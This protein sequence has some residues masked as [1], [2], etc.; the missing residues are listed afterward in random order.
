MEITFVDQPFKDD[1]YEAGLKALG[2]IG[3]SRVE[4]KDKRLVSFGREK[5]SAIH[6]ASGLGL[7]QANTYFDLVHGPESVE[8]S[9][10]LNLEMLDFASFFKAPFIRVFTGPLDENA[11]GT[12]RADEETWKL[13]VKGLKAICRA[14]AARNVFYP[15]ETHHGTL[16]ENTAS[17]FRLLEMVDEPNLCV[18]LQIPLKGEADVYES[19]RRLAPHV[20]HTHLNNFDVSGQSTYLEEGVH[21]IRREIAVLREHGYDGA[22]SVEHAYHHP[23]TLEIAKREFDFLSGIVRGLS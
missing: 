23:D 21:D 2:K 20:R 3:Y 13:A 8:K 19:T 16:A 9:L 7:I 17:I 4:T 5:I 11:V 1:Q 22:L 10:K 6:K 18:N 15:L 12:D 14:G